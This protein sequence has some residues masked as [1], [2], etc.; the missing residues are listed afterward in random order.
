MLRQA[1]DCAVRVVLRQQHGQLFLYCTRADGLRG[2]EQQDAPRGA[3]IVRRQHSGKNA[4]VVMGDSGREDARFFAAQIV[5]RGDGSD[6]HLRGIAVKPGDLVRNRL[7]GQRLRNGNQRFAGAIR[8]VGGKVRRRAVVQQ[9]KQRVAHGLGHFLYDCSIVF[10]AELPVDAAQGI[11]L[12]VIADVEQ[13]AGIVAGRGH[14]IIVAFHVREIRR[15]QLDHGLEGVGH[16]QNARFASELFSLLKQAEGIADPK[17]LRGDQEPT[18]VGA[19]QAEP[20]VFEI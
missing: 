2:G 4:L 20:H 10:P 17:L 1:A 18:T 16:N 14:G 9:Q 13:L 6:L 7:I 15:S 11:A 12:S 5:Q 8:S 19:V 3:Q